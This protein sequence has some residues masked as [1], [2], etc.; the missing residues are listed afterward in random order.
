MDNTVQRS[1]AISGGNNKVD[2]ATLSTKPCDT[3]ENV[4]MD[5][6]CNAI[7]TS[8]STEVPH[9][10][11]SKKAEN[12]AELEPITSLFTTF[13][14]E[15]TNNDINVNEEDEDYDC[16]DD[17]GFP[18]PPAVGATRSMRNTTAVNVTPPGVNGKVESG[19]SPIGW[20]ANQI[21]KNNHSASI[22]SSSIPWQCEDNTRK[23]LLVS[24]ISQVRT[25][26]GGGS[27]VRH[28]ISRT[29]LSRMHSSYPA[30]QNSFMTDIFDSNGAVGIP[31]AR[32]ASTSTQSGRIQHD[33]YTYNSG[34]STPGS[35]SG[36]MRSQSATTSQSLLNPVVVQTDTEVDDNVRVAVMQKI[37]RQAGATFRV[38]PRSVNTLIPNFASQG[39]T[40]TSI[41]TSRWTSFGGPGTPASVNALPL[42]GITLRDDIL[43][44]V[45]TSNT[46]TFT[47]REESQFNREELQY[48]SIPRARSYSPQSFLATPSSVMEEGNRAFEIRQEEENLRQ[49]RKKKKENKEEEEE[50]YQE[51]SQSNDNLRV[52]VVKGKYQRQNFV[53][54]IA[55]MSLGALVVVE[56]DRGEDIGT[57]EC[58]ESMD[59]YIAKTAHAESLRRNKLEDANRSR[60]NSTCSSNNNSNN[61]VNSNNNNNHHHISSH[62][63][64]DGHTPAVKEQIITPTNNSHNTNKNNDEKPN[65]NSQSSSSNQGKPFHES[66][67]LSQYQSSSQSLSQTQSKQHT[68]S[69]PRV[70]RL[71]VEADR[72][73]LEA[74]R[75]AEA[76]VLPEARS[77]V[78]RFAPAETV[79]VEDVEYQFDKQKITVYVRRKSNAVFVNFRRMQ[80]RLHRLLKCRIWMAYMDEVE[81]GWCMGK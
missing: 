23:P 71:A 74:L 55:N 19:P 75:A 13:D 54:D 8:D 22:S 21:G 3:G 78:N 80:R 44:P 46:P 45:S 48:I 56:G 27:T 58:I 39:F 16:D 7:H 65:P 20:N 25:R 32:T 6:N 36:M 64:H 43:R 66:P 17:D 2:K 1:P 62:N 4:N 5:G 50:E 29:Q 42:D 14:V 40:S 10:V 79:I 26:K 49:E 72:V 35:S 15:N 41:E 68:I 18:P 73:A 51:L 76:A 67:S 30:V 53:T 38:S 34:R 9:L 28:P 59:Y 47:M 11:N 12:E 24:D 31:R 81:S 60:S 61:S 63:S 57:V 70:Y 69:L 37:P 77:I 33:P 52:V